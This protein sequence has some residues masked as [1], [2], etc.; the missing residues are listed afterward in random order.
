MGINRDRD[1]HLDASDN[2]PAVPNDSQQDSDFD[3]L[4]DAC[5]PTPVP[6]PAQLL[7][8]LSGIGL[9]RVLDQRRRRN[10]R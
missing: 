8:L 5:D 7:M 4:G 9:L 1:I 2:C 6:E 10:A 3:S